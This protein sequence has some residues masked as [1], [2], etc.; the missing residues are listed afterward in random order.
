MKTRI[1]KTTLQFVR[2]VINGKF[3]N[4][5]EM[6]LDTIK[7]KVCNWYR[8]VNSYLVELGIEW[9]DIYGMTKED[10][11][12][13]MKIYDTQLWKDTL[14]KKSTLKYYKEG[15]VKMGYEKCYRNS[16]GS[17]FYAR[18]R[19]NSLKL[20]EAVGRGN[21]HHNKICKI[22]GIEEEDLLHFIIKCPFLEKR[23]NYCILD[24]NVKIP[25]ERLIQFLYRQNNHQETGKM[26]KDMWNARK[27]I[28]RFKEESRKKVN[29]KNEMN[30]LMMTDPGPKRSIAILNRERRGVS[31]LKG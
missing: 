12:C 29:S 7:R 2:E 6:M 22:C 11:N 21:P 9:E 4:I 10:I 1:M 20:E 27:T 24:K 19:L 5:R 3:V 31:E 18:A 30:N 14:E 16:A 15:K 17:M 13:M 8:I 23:R 28:L 26:I 25:E